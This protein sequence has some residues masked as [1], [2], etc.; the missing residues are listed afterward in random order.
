[1]AVLFTDTDPVP[2]SLSRLC[3][4]LD[5]LLS[6]IASAMR[7]AGLRNDIAFA[8]LLRETQYVVFTPRNIIIIYLCVIKVFGCLE[9]FVMINRRNKRSMYHMYHR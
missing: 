6:S 5:S 3:R 4:N 9:S 1:M 8:R 7:H 2:P